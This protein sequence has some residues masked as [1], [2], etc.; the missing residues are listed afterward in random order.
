MPPTLANGKICYIEMP[1]V[2]VQRSA[3]FVRQ[4][5]RLAPEAAWRRPYGVRR[6]DR[7]GQRHVG[8]GPARLRR[9]RPAL[10][11]H[12]R[13]DAATV[14]AVVAAGGAIVPPIGVDAPEVTARFRDRATTWSDSTSSRRSRAGDPLRRLAGA[15]ASRPNSDRPG[16]DQ[17]RLRRD[18]PPDRRQRNNPYEKLLLSLV[19]VDARRVLDW[20][21]RPAQWRIDVF[22]ARRCSITGYGD[23]PSSGTSREARDGPA[24][25]KPRKPMGRSPPMARTFRHGGGRA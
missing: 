10:L 4:G 20:E 3:E 11:H 22:R 14:V 15:P 2:D 6:H 8:R 1:A 5:F 13:R 17:S 16:Q 25:S 24:T 18:R 21:Q 12:G 9:A 23:T 7:R 19:P